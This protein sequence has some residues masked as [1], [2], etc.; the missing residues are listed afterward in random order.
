MSGTLT[1]ALY[2]GLKRLFKVISDQGP[3][4]GR[5][6]GWAGGQTNRQLG[7]DGRSRYKGMGA[8]NGGK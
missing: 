4:Q 2:F 7:M 3:A 6:R 1:T 8:R 5:I